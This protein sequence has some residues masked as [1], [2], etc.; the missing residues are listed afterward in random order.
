MK[1]LFLIALVITSI[2]SCK[3]KDKQEETTTNPIEQTESKSPQENVFDIN[4]LPISRENVGEFPYLSAPES[5]QYTGSKTK[6]YEEKLFFY[7]D[8]MVY[9]VGGK[10]YHARIHAKENVEFAATY[11]VN[12]Y[13]KAVE[14]LGGIEIYSGPLTKTSNKVLEE[15]LP[16]LKDLYDPFAYNYKQFLIRTAK[17]NIWIELIH[18]LNADMIDFTVV[19]EEVM[20]ETISLLKASDIQKQLDEKGKAVLYI[21]FDTDKASLKPEGEE[22]VNEIF[23]LLEQNKDLKLS[24]EGHTDNTGSAAHN[25]SL[26]EERAETVLKR[27][28][29]KGISKARLQ[30]KGFGHEKPFVA[31]DTEENK[32]KNRRVELIKM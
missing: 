18:G 19:K 5:Y 22:A 31:N 14:K 8:S 26:S 30:A 1:R 12:N 28:I 15:D 3:A 24:I 2:A 17:E 27:L 25:Q 29:T 20:K 13:K 16:Y 23:L 6:E 32:A 11:V 21:N 7:N 9:K 4:Q 10:Y